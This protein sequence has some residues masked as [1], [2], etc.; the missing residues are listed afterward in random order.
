MAC[1]V[2]DENKKYLITIVQDLL[3]DG[4]DTS[5]SNKMNFLKGLLKK[6]SKQKLI[7]TKTPLQT[8]NYRMMIRKAA[9][10]TLF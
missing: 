3:S 5:M 10:K 7:L 8:W 4:I 1:T 6:D 2:Q 9:V